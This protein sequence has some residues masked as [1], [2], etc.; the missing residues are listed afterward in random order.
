MSFKYSKY[1]KQ[2]FGLLTKSSANVIL[3]NLYLILTRTRKN[4]NN[5]PQ[6]SYLLFQFLQIFM[7]IT[8]KRKYEFFRLFE[9]E[10]IGY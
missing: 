5:D 9:L 7:T 1:T 3:K 2:K 4:M 8:N 10:F 6:K